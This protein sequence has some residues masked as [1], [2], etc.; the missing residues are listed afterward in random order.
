[1]TAQ[2]LGEEHRVIRGLMKG[3]H[4]LLDPAVLQRDPEPAFLQLRRL[5]GCLKVHFEHE[6]TGLY[7]R[8][9][10]SPEAH[11]RILARRAELELCTLEPELLGKVRFWSAGDR[12]RRDPE[13]FVQ[14]A[15]A[16]LGAVGHRLGT[17]ERGVFRLLERAG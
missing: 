12:I 14:D 16:L 4:D 17:E 8:L 13:G 10:A 3:L 7:G 1:V 2:W 11:V 6:R 15:K 9:A 5:G